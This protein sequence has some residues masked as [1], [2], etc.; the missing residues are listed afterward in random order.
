MAD[1]VDE[2]K[3][4]VD[5]VSLI[6]EYIELKKAGRNF[7]A[8][9]PFHSE[10]TPSFMVSPELQMYKCF[11]CGESGDVFSFLEKYD[12]ME[13]REAL[14]FLADKVGVK[15][16]SYRPGEESQKERLYQLH[17][18]ASKFYNYVLLAHRAGKAALN[19]LTVERGLDL[20]TIKLFQIGFSPDV[21]GVIGKFLV[22]KKKFSLKELEASGVGIIRG[23]SIFDKFGGRIIFPLFDHRGN[24]A[25]FAGR[26]LPSAKTEMGKYINSPETPIY[27]KSR[28]LFGLNFA[29]EEIKRLGEAVIVEGELDM[30]SSYHHG[31]KNVVAIKGSALT[32]EQ[33]RLL[34]RF[35]NKIV[36]ALD[37]DFAGDIAAR[38]GIVIAQK[39]GLE[40]TV[41][42]M[43]EYK[44]PDEAVRKNPEFYK[45]AIAEA[46]GVWD[47]IIDSIFSQGDVGTGEGK[48]KVSREVV[49]VLA[50]IPDKIVQAH[51]IE[52]VAKRLGVPEGAVSQEVETHLKDKK[53]QE[54]N[55]AVNTKEEMN[56]DAKKTRRQLLEE[57]LL[58]LAFQSEPTVL[59]SVKIK[60]LIATPLPKR[61][62]E[63]YLGFAKKHRQFSPSAFASKLPKE[64]LSG[65]AGMVL[66]EAQDFLERPDLFKR[67]IEFVVSEL[68]MVDMRHKL[69]VV[70]AK[71]RK[72]EESDQKDKLKDAQ[73]KFGELTRKLSK[74][75]ETPQEGIIFGKVRP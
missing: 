26:I 71:I 17:T 69:E 53:E 47:F 64:L 48:A 68:E 1:Q 57:R 28:L 7:R 6:G 18:L 8:L 31:I 74:F 10:K 39:E 65:F 62:Y 33:V 20:E 60:S 30:I 16:I 49:P 2:I 59:E 51:Y 38:R 36:L 5:I 13:F 25:G 15:L 14:K 29:K 41:A 34:S 75:E 12:G 23:A 37:S 21:P 42:K 45:K 72:F 55:L 44:D 67:E 56:L 32:E 73:E 63:E 3:Q 70:G 4:K 50:Q 46:V 27:H 43:G 52:E 11:G 66:K 54:P 40:I 58:S 9:C 35:T 24:I 22:D 19:Y 61:V